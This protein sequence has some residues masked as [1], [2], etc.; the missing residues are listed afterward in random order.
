MTPKPNEDASNLSPS[1]ISGTKA[2]F[3]DSQERWI[4]EEKVGWMQ[5]HTILVYSMKSA[6]NLTDAQLYLYNDWYENFSPFFRILTHI[7]KI[8]VVIKILL[9][10][11]SHPQFLFCI[12]ISDF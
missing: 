1:K 12:S 7:T 6:H 10:D 3:Y 9:N 5:S 2:Y 4:I 11:S 8:K